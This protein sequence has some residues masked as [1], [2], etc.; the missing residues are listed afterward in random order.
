MYSLNKRI[1]AL[2]DEAPAR[3]GFTLIELLVVIAIIAILAAMLLPAL[4]AA[5]QRAQAAGCMNN[6]H[7]MLLAW[8][9][10]ADDNNDVLAANDFPYLTAYRGAM[11]LTNQMHNWVVG[12]MA[13]SL[14]ANG[15]P[16]SPAIAE[17]SDRNTQ[18]SRYLPNYK[19]YHCPADNYINPLDGNI[20]LRSYSMNSAVGTC[21]WTHF[22]PPNYVLGS[23][24]GEGWLQGSTYSNTQLGPWLTYGKLSSFTRPGPSKTWVFIDENPYSINDGSM[25]VSAVAT[26]GNTSI[27]DFP[28]GLHGAA[29][30]L[31]FADGHSI[32]H[33]WSD[34]RTYS[35]Q[36]LVSGGQG[37]TTHISQS[38]D[39]QDCFF[40]API[41]SALR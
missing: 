32:I 18:L 39:N 21:F 25:A 4:A 22:N 29:G 36:G 35:P 41:T 16:N 30:G 1:L 37:G 13:K 33:A 31:S 6:T 3:R 23:A 20:N 12:T 14:D 11:G 27:I 19:S 5:K 26:P 24:V 40:L 10:Y 34:K 38:P 15:A 28:S 9:M 7:Q 2:E 17:L 8:T